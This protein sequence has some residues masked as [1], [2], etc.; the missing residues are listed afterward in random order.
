MSSN[1]FESGFRNDLSNVVSTAYKGAAGLG[2]I[3]TIIGAVV[4]GFLSVVLVGV[5]INLIRHPQPQTDPNGKVI[6]PP[7]TTPGW[8]LVGLG[9][10]I[11][12]SAGIS[13]W[14]V[15]HYKGFAALIGA[16]SIYKMF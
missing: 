6:G 2:R 7:T 15:N 13:L 12:L 5:G 4:G 14:L 10:F 3:E 16:E 11:A 8:I 9:V 1:Y